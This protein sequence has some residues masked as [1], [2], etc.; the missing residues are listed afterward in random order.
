MAYYTAWE[1]TACRL[2]NDDGDELTAT[3]KAGINSPAQ[4]L[5]GDVFRCRWAI[6]SVGTYPSTRGTTV[7]Y[8]LNGGAW[9]QVSLGSAVV[10]RVNSAN[11]A[12]NLSQNTT[13]QISSGTFTVGTCVPSTSGGT[14]RNVPVGNY[15]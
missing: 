4:I 2:R 6:A 11:A 13:S 14:T 9:T 15:T 7:Y 3:W 10:R 5:A 12:F 1:V 8:S